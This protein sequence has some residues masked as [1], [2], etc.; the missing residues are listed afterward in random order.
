MN[1]FLLSSTLPHHTQHVGTGDRRKTHHDAAE[2]GTNLSNLV[3]RAL[4]CLMNSRADLIA[5]D[6]SPLKDS[7]QSQ[8]L[9]INQRG[10]LVWPWRLHARLWKALLPMTML[11][12]CDLKSSTTSEIV[13]SAVFRLWGGI[14]SISE[15]Y[16]LCHYVI[17][18]VLCMLDVLQMKVAHLQ[19]VTGDHCSQHRSV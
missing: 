19:S 18:I 6:G 13:K 17:F 10:V 8:K 16:S 7:M 2:T 11:Y 1:L 15:I 12:P 4:S 9:Y 3:K 5:H 14:E